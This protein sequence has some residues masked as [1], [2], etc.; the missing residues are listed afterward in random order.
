[1]VGITLRSVEIHPALSV[2]AMDF[3]PNVR[4][5][6]PRGAGHVASAEEGRYASP[7]PS[8]VA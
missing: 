6:L 7:F 8:L 5:S 1:M 4:L 2:Y 3:R